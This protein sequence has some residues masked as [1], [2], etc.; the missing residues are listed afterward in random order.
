MQK[1]AM[2]GET[3]ALVARL[4]VEGAQAKLGEPYVVSLSSIEGHGRGLRVSL[5]IEWREVGSLTEGP[6]F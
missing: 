5:L 6:G 2:G 4:A 1:E 3:I